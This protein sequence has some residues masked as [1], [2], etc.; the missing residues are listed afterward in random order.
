[1]ITF[2]Q[3][4]KVCDLL[5]RSSVA[6]VVVGGWAIF[7]HGYERTTKDIDILV[8]PDPKNIK[9]IKTA[10]SDIMM[11]ACSELEADDV[12]NNIVV[13]MVGED[14][15]LD[16][17]AK[18]GDIDY[19]TAKKHIIIEKAD[20]VEIPV[21]DVDTMLKL[22]EGVRDADKKDYTFLLGKKEYLAKASRGKKWR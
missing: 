12:K 19:A 17:M 16:L 1:M 2:G 5:N 15:V 7:I 9:K 14:I 8:D 18:I 21:A 4:T 11:E 20:D 3:L 22:K 13:R 6:Y 10:L